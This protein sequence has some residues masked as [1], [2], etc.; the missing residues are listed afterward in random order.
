MEDT[1]SKLYDEL[2][3]ISKEIQPYYEIDKIKPYSVYIWTKGDPEEYTSE[4]VFDI[5]ADEI[6]FYNKRH[7]ILDE[8]IPVIKKIQSKLKQIEEITGWNND[9]I[10]SK[11]KK[12]IC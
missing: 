4:N 6:I 10:E 12:E 9:F 7:Q 5:T 2:V 11:I 1:F 8:A 3:L